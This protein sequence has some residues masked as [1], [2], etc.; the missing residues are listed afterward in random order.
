MLACFDG[1]T[2]H[3][4]ES[5]FF[6]DQPIESIFAM[7]SGTTNRSTILLTVVCRE[8]GVVEMRVVRETMQRQVPSAAA[9]W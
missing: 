4:F 1:N 5:G 9:H 2:L 3:V 8:C 7:V 6:A